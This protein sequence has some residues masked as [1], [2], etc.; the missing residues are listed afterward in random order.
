MWRARARWN[1]ALKYSV[2]NLCAMM[3]SSCVLAFCDDVIYLLLMKTEYFAK[4]GSG[5]PS[6]KLAQSNGVSRRCHRGADAVDDD[7]RCGTDGLFPQQPL[8][9]KTRSFAQTGSGHIKCE[10]R[11]LRNRH[12]RFV[13]RRSDEEPPAQKRLLR[14]CVPVLRNRHRHR[15]RQ[16]TD[17]W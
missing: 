3:M 6:G 16:L 8:R 14:R 17:L 13:H 12:H 4:T 2:A 1:H 15:P 9:K 7:D 10:D 5:Q 11:K